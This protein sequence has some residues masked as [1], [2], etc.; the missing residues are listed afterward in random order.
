MQWLALIDGID[1]CR[2]MVLF[3][4]TNILT[5]GCVT[6]LDGITFVI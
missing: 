6:S 3:Q 5:P 4:Q 2:V 1:L